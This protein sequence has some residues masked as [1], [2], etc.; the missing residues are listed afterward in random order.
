MPV[1]TRKPAI[2]SRAS[3]GKY[4]DRV[5]CEHDATGNYDI[6]IDG[7]LRFRLERENQFPEFWYLYLVVN[8]VRTDP[9]VAFEIQQWDIIS[10]LERGEHWLPPDQVE[11]EERV[12]L[13]AV[14]RVRWA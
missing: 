3:S 12:A 11:R 6:L 14:R 10:Q 13:H 8:G 9:S 4:A 1:S 5:C 2:R 7:E